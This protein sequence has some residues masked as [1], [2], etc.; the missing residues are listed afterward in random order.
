VAF[1]FSFFRLGKAMFINVHQARTGA[2]VS[3]RKT[4]IMKRDFSSNS[5][6]RSD[7]E[8]LRRTMRDLLRAM[9]PAHHS[10]ASLVICQTAA[11]LPEF[12][13]ARC[14]ALFS[15]LPS[16]PDVRLLIEEAWAEGKRVALPL[17]IKHKSGPQLDWHNVTSWDDVVLPGLFGLREPDPLKCPRLRADE[18][19][20]AFVPGLA[21]DHNGYRLGRGGGFYDYFLDQAPAPLPRF[22]I[23]FNCQ[24]VPQVP[25]EPHDQ[26]LATYVTEEKV[27]KSNS[28][29]PGH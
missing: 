11:H 29:G 7:K 21:F 9:N 27:W 28:G 26:A 24:R 14:V 17:M 1:F 18:I 8:K 12:K 20:C 15:P 6:L 2:T 16:E 19:D 10:E 5:D 23:M 3:C 22:G 25:R 4:P 13:K